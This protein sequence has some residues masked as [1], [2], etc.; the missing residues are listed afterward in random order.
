MY[1]C[2]YIYIYIYLRTHTEFCKV[3][4]RFWL[5]VV[6]WFSSNLVLTEWLTN[7]M[8]QSLSWEANRSSAGQEVSLIVW[9]P[10]VYYRIHTHPP[11][12]PILSQINP[13]HASPSLFLKIHFNIVLASTARSSKLSLS[14]WSPHKNRAC[15]SSLPILATCLA[16]L[17][18]VFWPPE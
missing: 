18:L 3:F 9:N 4:S 14:L 1:V 5:C 17:F 8:E 15:S 13:I 6:G 12:L 10:K 7:S 16:R 11:T 2:M